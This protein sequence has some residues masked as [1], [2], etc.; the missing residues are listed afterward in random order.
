MT[1]HVARAD[2]SVAP[3]IGLVLSGLLLL[4]PSAATP[5][6]AV[7]MPAD[8]LGPDVRVPLALSL[9]SPL[10]VLQPYAAAGARPPGEALGPLADRARPATSLPDVTAGTGLSWRVR[11]RLEFFG[12]YRFLHLRGDDDDPL[13]RAGFS[14][15]LY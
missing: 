9:E 14:I 1:S 10:G 12:E 6:P 8:V 4:A 5:Q 7:D 11:D 15:R 3:L 13:F 2:R